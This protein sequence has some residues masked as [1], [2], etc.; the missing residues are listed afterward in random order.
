M[1]KLWVILALIFSNNVYSVDL[2]KHIDIELNKCKEAVS[3]TPALADCYQAASEAWDAELNHQYKLLMQ[4]LSEPAKT[5][6]KESQRA[7]V[8]YKDTYF[9][10]I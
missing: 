8:K 1:K 6:L 7:W 4:D 3:T 9:S 2:E 10:G 5:K